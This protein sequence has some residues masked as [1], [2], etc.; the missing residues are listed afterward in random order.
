MLV[1]HQQKLSLGTRAHRNAANFKAK[2]LLS[3]KGLQCNRVRTIA[4]TI[5]F[6]TFCVTATLLFALLDMLNGNALQISEKSI[7]SSVSAITFM[8]EIPHNNIEQSRHLPTPKRLYHFDYSWL[9]DPEAVRRHT[10]LQRAFLDMADKTAFSTQPYVYRP[11]LP[12]MGWG[13][14]LYDIAHNFALAMLLERP[15]F[16]SFDIKDKHNVLQELTS[17]CNDRLAHERFIRECIRC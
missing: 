11:K 9:S 4:Y 1:W 13:N 8:P 16:M 12:A 10:N 5:I 15:F 2:F 7:S 17:S 6:A 3:Q 14:L